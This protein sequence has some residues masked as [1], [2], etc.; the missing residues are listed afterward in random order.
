M[1][2]EYSGR[3]HARPGADHHGPSSTSFPDNWTPQ[4]VDEAREVINTY[5]DFLAPFVQDRKRHL[6][7]WGQ[8]HGGPFPGRHLLRL[9]D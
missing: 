7:T 4:R 5:F 8:E 3:A 1:P 2:R 6:G 9:D